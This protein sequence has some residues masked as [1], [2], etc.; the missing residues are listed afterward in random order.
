[1]IGNTAIQLT[2]NG[3]DDQTGIFSQSVSAG[4]LI[5]FQITTNDNRFG[6]A[7]VTISDFSVAADPVDTVIPTPAMLPGLIGMG[8]AA[9][10]KKRQQNASKSGLS[11]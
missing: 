3:A 4:Q 5:G 1:M 11:D 6:R 8:I 2:D 9:W 10:R 7:S